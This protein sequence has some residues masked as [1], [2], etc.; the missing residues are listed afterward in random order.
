MRNGKI[1]ATQVGFGATVFAM[2]CTL[3][4]IKQ[5]EAKT[6]SGKKRM[7]EGVKGGKQ[8]TSKN[9]KNDGKEEMDRG[10]DGCVGVICGLMCRMA[11]RDIKKNRE[12]EAW[13]KFE[14]PRWSVCPRYSRHRFNKYEWMETSSVRQYQRKTRT[15]RKKK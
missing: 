14:P 10:M 12:T 1:S 5:D 11:E 2:S 4:L 9:F 6:S 8:M 15:K 7:G 13:E 3:G